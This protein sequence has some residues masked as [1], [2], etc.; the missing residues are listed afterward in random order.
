MAGRLTCGN[1]LGL[2]IRLILLQRLYLLLI[3]IHHLTVNDLLL[4]QMNKKWIRDQYSGHQDA[5]C[6]MRVSL[7]LQESQD[8]FIWKHSGD[9][10]YTVRTTYH[11]HMGEII[12]NSHIR[13]PSNLRS[14]QQIKVPTKVKILAWCAIRGC[15]STRYSFRPIYKKKMQSQTYN[16]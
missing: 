6:I 13:S 8:K 4:P 5:H 3:D 1:K 16:I 15:L 10:A 14:S 9:D 2:V 12:Y 7:L 11:V